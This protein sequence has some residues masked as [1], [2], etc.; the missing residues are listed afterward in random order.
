MPLVYQTFWHHVYQ[1]ERRLEKIDFLKPLWMVIRP[2]RSVIQALRRRRRPTYGFWTDN[3]IGPKCTVQVDVHKLNQLQRLT[4]MS[5]IENRLS[6]TAG[7][8][9]LTSCVCPANRQMAIR[10]RIP[11]NSGR[12]LVLEF[13]NHV[14]DPNGRRLSFLVESTNLFDEQNSSPLVKVPV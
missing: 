14:I 7:G 11:A 4:G 6:I 13:S 12:R 10:F 9:E 2:I 1:T 5:P 8:N 3:W